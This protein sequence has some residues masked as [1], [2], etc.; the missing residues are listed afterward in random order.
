GGRS[1]DTGRRD[2]HELSGGMQQR[3]VIALSL[4]LKPKVV[5]LDEPTSALDVMTQTNIINL[6]KDLK[7]TEH[8]SYIFIT[9]DLGLA[10]ELADLVGIM[11]A[12]QLVELGLC[13]GVCVRPKHPYTGK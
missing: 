13:E 8:L 10:S 2:S 6:L 9:H 4:I 3:V 1:C 12:G 11:Y 5:I 7:T